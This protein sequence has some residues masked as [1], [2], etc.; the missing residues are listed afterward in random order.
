MMGGSDG[1]LTRFTG[2]GLLGNIRWIQ[3]PA[4]QYYAS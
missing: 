2:E 4:F 3:K 1:W